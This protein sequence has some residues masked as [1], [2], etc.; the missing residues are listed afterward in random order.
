M[1]ALSVL[2]GPALVMA[3]MTK[4]GN[5]PYR[6]LCQAFGASI[7]MSEMAVVRSLRQ[8]RRGE[9]ALIQR[10]PDEQCF[11]VQ[12]AGR[13]ADE[14]RW[15]AELVASRGA[16]LVDLNLGCPIDEFT[17]RGLGSALLRQPRRVETLVAAMK[18]G[19]AALPVTVKIRL[20][21][22]EDERNAVDVARAAE[23][24]GADGITVHGRTRSARY[25]FA[26]DWAAIGEVATSVQ[27]PVVGNGD[28]LFPEDIERG[29]TISGVRAVMIARGAL[30]K[31]WIFAEA[32]GQV[33]DDSAEARIAIY[34]QY[35]RLAR[36][37]FG[38]DERGHTRLRPFLVWHLGLWCRHI[39]RQADGSYVPMQERAVHVSP[40]TPL[41][42]LLARPEPA[43][44]EWLADRLMAGDEM[45]PEDLPGD[46]ARM[47]VAD[48]RGRRQVETPAA[49]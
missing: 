25:R 45:C 47:P 39:P 38:D 1:S 29:R 7:T 27:I 9:F 26:A 49:G 28:I 31:P 30:I 37:H 14:L 35:V 21:W 13:T 36:E 34:R 22:N 2:S 4:G 8:R 46:I 10:A 23:A 41:E 18:A 43:V 33:V 17:R 3:P 16:D 24:G 42:A 44:H 11:G 5:L 20:G 6:R 15:G 40:R 19:A 48:A 32:R 12:L